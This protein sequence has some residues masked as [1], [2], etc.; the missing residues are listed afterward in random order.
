MHRTLALSIGLGINDNAIGN[1]ERRI[2][3][4]AEMTYNLVLVRLILIGLNEIASSGKC[5]LIDIFFNFVRTHADTVVR[6]TYAPLLGTH[7]H[8]NL[9][10]FLFRRPIF[11]DQSKFF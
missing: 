6:E 5:N 3:A 8:K 7:L 4:E 10:A 9:I 1:H 2:K 11:S